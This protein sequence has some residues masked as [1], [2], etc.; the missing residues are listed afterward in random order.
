MDEFFEEN[1]FISQGGLGSLRAGALCVMGLLAH[2]IE[3]ASCCS[4]ARETLL[5][6]DEEE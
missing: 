2:H 4:M 6:L 5:L 3:D 1:A